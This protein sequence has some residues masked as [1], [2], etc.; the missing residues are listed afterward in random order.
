L[1]DRFRVRRDETAFATLVRRHGRMVLGVCR[2]V[3][4]HAQ[5]AED[6]FQATFLVL[7]RRPDA[8][9]RRAAVGGWLYGVAYRTALA[10]RVRNA[11]RAVREKQVNEMPHPTIASEE[12]WRELVPLL[13]QELARLPEKYRL[14]VILCELEGRSR[15]E[16][17]RQLAVPEGTLSSRL[18]TARKT[19]ARRLARH[20]PLPAAA[21]VAS[22]LS[23]GASAAVPAALV[24][25]TVRAASGAIPAQVAALAEGM[26]KAMLLSKLKAISW[27]A[28]LAVSISAGAIG[29]TYRPTASAAEEPAR[30]ARDDLEALR[31]EIEALRKSLQ[32]TRSRV[33]TLEAEVAT[34]KGRSEAQ[35]TPKRAE[36]TKAQPEPK[37]AE[38]LLLEAAKRRQAAVE[39]LTR[40]R[41]TVLLRDP[42]AEAEAAL[43]KLKKDPSS[44]Q[45][46]QEAA[47]ALERAAKKL[48]DRAKPEAPQGAPAPK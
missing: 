29:V 4:G 5:D 27:V 2:R 23:Q 22:L 45:T 9:A 38:V 10:A 28:L 6:A 12:T 18:A 30:S 3:V 32:A 26:M 24:A 8:V 48:R 46:Q 37:A 25:S 44:K 42:L 19:L 31:L 39:H 14:P 13:D 34:L 7:A 17:A 1:L 16:V 36:T 33:Q 41:F 21:A 47:E 43:Q 11:R 15:K 20:G 35:P 40:T